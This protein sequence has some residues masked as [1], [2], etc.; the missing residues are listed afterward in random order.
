MPSLTLDEIPIREQ[1]QAV[2]R[3]ARRFQCE[4]DLRIEGSPFDL[5]TGYVLVT[6]GEQK[7]RVFVFGVSPDGQVS[8]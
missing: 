3:V 5:P 1:R 7:G 8:S 4:D 6:I 2:E